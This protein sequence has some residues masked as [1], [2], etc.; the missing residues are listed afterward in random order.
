M[1]G[2]LIKQF[3]K[4]L[5]LL[6][7]GFLI[8]TTVLSTGS[9]QSYADEYC[10]YTVIE[11]TVETIQQRHCDCVI[12]VGEYNG[13][14]G[15][16][17]YL[18]DIDIHYKDI[19]TD[20]PIHSDSHG[21]YISEYDINLKTAKAIV[22]KLRS[23]GVN[24]VLQVANGKSQDLNAAG[25]ISNKSNPYVYLSI[26]HNYFD[27]SGS[28]R[29]YFAMSKHGDYKS[30]IV[31]QRLSDSIRYNGLVKQRETQTNS[32]YIGELNAIH[33]STIGAL[34]ELGFF[35]NATELKNICSDKYVDYVSNN[36]AN[37]LSKIIKEMK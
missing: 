33:D 36:L 28:A 8:T 5:T 10:S 30:Q 1:L 6:L 22:S 9:K 37:E 12:R 15:K 16:R 29:G 7:V 18:N 32:S 34:L 27:G 19:P 35:D 20:I 2:I 31:A 3:K 14:A 25:R 13:K 23:N 21:A 17:I 26:H 4:A 24:A 11:Q